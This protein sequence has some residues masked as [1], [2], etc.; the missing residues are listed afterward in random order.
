MSLIESA[1]RHKLHP[2]PYIQDLLR[3]IPTHPQRDIE[4]LLPD[5][6]SPTLTNA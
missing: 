3:R 4:L 2:F 1:K 6:W 5:K